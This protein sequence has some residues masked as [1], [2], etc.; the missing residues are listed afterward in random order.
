M[1]HAKP[2]IPFFH[3][4]EVTVRLAPQ[5]PFLYRPFINRSFA[6]F[7]RVLRKQ[8]TDKSTIKRSV[9]RRID[10]KNNS[11][12]CLDDGSMLGAK[13][14]SYPKER[15]NKNTSAFIVLQRNYFKGNRF[16]HFAF[17][18][19]LSILVLRSNVSMRSMLYLKLNNI[20]TKICSFFSPHNFSG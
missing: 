20:Y 15:E 8:T 3:H 6:V 13:P 11:C 2:H 4:P 17:L 1:Q 18:S 16:I 12:S 9:D 5:I 10:R 7:P 14:S 19:L